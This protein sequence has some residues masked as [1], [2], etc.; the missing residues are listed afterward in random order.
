MATNDIRCSTKATF[1]KRINEG[2][3]LIEVV[4][5]SIRDS[6]IDDQRI[7]ILGFISIDLYLFVF[8]KFTVHFSI[9][10]ILITR[11]PAAHGVFSSVI[12]WGTQR[13]HER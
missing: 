7:Y 13:K 10:Y 1:F 11:N 5:D 12:P 3:L 8:E 9:K 6:L 2:N 4:S